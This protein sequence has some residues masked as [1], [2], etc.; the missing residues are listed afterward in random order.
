MKKSILVRT[1][2]FVCLVIVLGFCITSIISYHSNRGLFEQDIERVSAL[3]SEGVYHQIDSLFT[4][5]IHISMTM[6]NDQLLKTFLQN[7][8]NQLDDDQFLTAMQSY[9][10]AYQ[11]KYGYDSV[12]LVSTATNRYYHYNGLDRILTTDNPENVW[13]YTFL[14][15]PEELSVVIDNDEVAH[16]N[17]AITVFI[18]CKIT[19]ENGRIMGVVGVG[20]DTNSIQNLLRSYEEQFDVHIYLLDQ[21]G[22]IEI[23]TE[24]TGFEGVNLFEAS[25]Y[26]TLADSLTADRSQSHAFWYANENQS[27]YIITQYVPILDWFLVIDN[28]TAALNQQ[29]QYQFFLGMLIIIAVII[30]VLLVITN[31]I[32]KYNKQIV[33]LTVAREQEH[34]NLFQT[35]TEKMYDNIY[36]LDVTHNCAASE[37][38]VAYFASLGVP[39]QTPY[40]QALHIIADKQIKAEF[41][42]GYL[43]TFT[44]EHVLAA[45]AAGTDS[46][47]YDFMMTDDGEHYYWMR[48]T[49]RIFYWD[50]D[51][52]IRMFIYRQNIDK[53]KQQEALLSEQLQRDSLSG[54]YNKAATQKHIQTLLTAHPQQCFAFFIVDI[55][56]FKLVNDTY[57]HAVG[58]AVI[59]DFAA[60][61]KSQFRPTDVVGRIGGDEFVA[62]VPLPTTQQ[63]A[64][65]AQALL[66]ALRYTYSGETASC[67]LTPSI[68]ISIAPQSGTDF[69]TLYK[70]ADLALYQTKQNGK[71]G[72]TID[73]S[74][75]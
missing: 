23:S 75:L 37:A 43:D 10:L 58:D 16:A 32:R 56:N 3:T 30:F 72:F 66:A 42:Q 13:Y 29:L 15:S 9:L 11:E 28:D 4:K 46:L 52:S 35:A 27:G 48:I 5:P 12:F 53:E 20:F 39:E 19:D 47:R 1:N 17:N 57:G 67:P 40:D 55:D 63:I 62:F 51:Q 61:L 22:T 50:D 2:I 44:P 41:R 70:N 25:V 64:E 34:R 18:N 60:V 65:K 7:E 14:Q 59:A 73:E 68:G 38:T 24:Q 54:L 31:I 74:S 21:D 36:E 49:A 45:Y 6:A 69:E 33:E 71:N 26:G 8:E